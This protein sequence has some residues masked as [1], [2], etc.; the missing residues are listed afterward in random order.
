MNLDV[1]INK[2]NKKFQKA[3]DILSKIRD[4]K[5]THEP[6]FNSMN[7]KY[8]LSDCEALKLLLEIM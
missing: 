5:I 7:I 8:S 6:F 2:E 3:V 4:G 1:E